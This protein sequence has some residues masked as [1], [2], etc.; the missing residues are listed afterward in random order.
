[1][2]L[3][4]KVAAMSS[5]HLPIRTDLLLILLLPY[6]S[7]SLLHYVHNAEYLYDYPNMPAWVSS[8][9]IYSAW[10]CVTALGLVGYFLIRCG[11]QL[12]GLFLLTI[13]SVL[14]LD[15]L[16]HYTLASLSAHTFTMNM[17]IWLETATA[18]LLLIAL[19]SLILRRLQI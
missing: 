1:V 12:V 8:A 14:G 10:L 9:H 18:V 17:T 13:Y 5:E 11:Y 3:S 15:G 19:L 2:A 7:A 4:V 16:S 6:A